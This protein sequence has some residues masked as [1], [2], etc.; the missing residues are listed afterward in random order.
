MGGGSACAASACSRSC[1]ARAVSDPA[2]SCTSPIISSAMYLCSSSNSSAVS[3]VLL[4]YLSYPQQPQFQPSRQQ[5]ESIQA[6]R[7]AARAPPP[8]PGGA[9]GVGDVPKEELVGCAHALLVLDAHA[10]HLRLAAAA[11]RPA[12]RTDH[13][14]HSTQMSGQAHRPSAPSS[15]SP[16]TYG[17]HPPSLTPFAPLA[18]LPPPRCLTR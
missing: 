12:S 8:V 13:P 2:V 7:L 17:T 15:S 6:S 1:S 18:A 4:C 10:V 16:A 11:P 9:V 14:Q 3:R 5:S